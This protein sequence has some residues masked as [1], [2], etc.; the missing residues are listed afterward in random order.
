MKVVLLKFRYVKTKKTDIVGVFANNELA[1]KFV[2]E[3]KKLDE[4]KYGEWSHS[5]RELIS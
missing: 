3:H 5:D 4:F 2:D 1:R